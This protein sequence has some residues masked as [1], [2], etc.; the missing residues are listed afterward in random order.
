VTPT[1]RS[2]SVSYPAGAAGDEV[3]ALT[4]ELMAHNAP[5]LGH[6]DPAMLALG[7]IV[8]IVPV[9]S[10]PATAAAAKTGAAVAVEPASDQPTAAPATHE[11]VSGDSYWAIA[12][13]VLGAE[14]TSAEVLAKTEALMALNGSRLG[15]EDPAMIH[16]GDVVLLEEARAQPVTQPAGAATTTEAATTTDKAPGSVIK[17]APPATQDAT[18]ETLAP[19][20]RWSSPWTRLLAPTS[21]APRAQ[22]PTSAPQSEQALIEWETISPLA[23]AA[24]N[25]VPDGRPPTTSAA[26]PGMAVSGP[27]APRSLVARAG[28]GAVTLTWLSPAKSVW[29]V[30]QYMI[31]H[32]TSPYGPWANLGT[33]TGYSY[34][35]TRM[36]DGTFHYFR[37]A[38]YNTPNNEWGY[39]DVVAAAPATIAR[40][41]DSPARVPANVI[42]S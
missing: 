24:S 25:R 15:Y 35:A 29:T 5:Q 33:T 31:Q 6:D 32:A 3:W 4:D 8:E 34:T 1:G 30:D 20:T 18:I 27:V 40:V 26:L 14:A 39:S 12:E 42:A 2:L 19:T 41:P 23:P 7:D 22:T 38:A 9:S 11:V 17:T 28:D 16:P 21:G 37:V 10:Q 36:T 13:S